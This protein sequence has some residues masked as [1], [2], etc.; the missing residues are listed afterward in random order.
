MNK[1]KI[2]EDVKTT[3]EEKPSTELAQNDRFNITKILNDFNHLVYEYPDGLT[4]G[5]RLAGISGT[6][7]VHVDIVHVLD[8]RKANYDNALMAM[9]AAVLE[10]V[11]RSLSDILKDVGLQ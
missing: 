5:V 9:Q 1:E 11:D 7:G 3:N 6:R 2:A 10:T 8:F 4:L